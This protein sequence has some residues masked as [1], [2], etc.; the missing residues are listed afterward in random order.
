MVSKK[1]LFRSIVLTAACASLPPVGYAA[2]SYPSKPVTIIMPYS[3]GGSSDIMTRAVAKGL[4][5]MWG[6][7]AIV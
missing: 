2:E 4:S 5:D 6:R 1:L 7:Q 3:A